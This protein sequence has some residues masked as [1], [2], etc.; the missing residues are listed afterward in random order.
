MAK[1]AQGI[2]VSIDYNADTKAGTWYKLSDHNRQPMG[3]TYNLI[4]STD[5]MANGTLRKYIVARKFVISADWKDFPSLDSN[6]VDYSTGGK[7]SAWIKAFYEGNYGN[8]IYVKLIFAQEDVVINSIPTDISYKDSKNTD[9]QVFLAYM[10]TFTY[11]VSKRRSST[12]LPQTTT[13][14]GYDYVDLTI[15]FTEV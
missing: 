4:E 1:I 5:R 7:A 2:Q 11:N 6:L 15:E 3:I 13:N 14:N 12:S 9:G 8:P 10:S